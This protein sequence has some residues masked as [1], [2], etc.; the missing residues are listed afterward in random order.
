M[1]ETVKLCLGGGDCEAKC[2]RS[3]S[4]VKLY[5]ISFRFTQKLSKLAVV[6]NEESY[7]NTHYCRSKMYDSN[8]GKKTGICKS[9]LI[10]T[11]FAI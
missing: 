7:F 2:L 8:K 5:R 11:V 1:H 6:L 3:F 10:E 4:Q 9:V